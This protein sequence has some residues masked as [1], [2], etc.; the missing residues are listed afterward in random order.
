MRPVRG[1]A[2]RAIF[3]NGEASMSAARDQAARLLRSGPE[4]AGS[5]EAARDAAALAE[6][7]RAHLSD[8]T[9]RRQ[10]EAPASP[11]NEKPAVER[12]AAGP[13]APPKAS[14]AI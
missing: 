11:A 14:G 12:P 5:D 1:R 7:L 2:R 9:A 8:E 6:Q 4:T 10:G 13:S 3:C